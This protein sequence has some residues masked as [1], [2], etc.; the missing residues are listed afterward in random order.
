M[1]AGAGDD[2]ARDRQ[3]GLDARRRRRADP[4][5]G[6]EGRRADVPRRPAV[7]VPRRHGDVRGRRAG[8]RAGHDRPRARAELARLPRARC[9]GRRSAMP[10]RGPPRSPA[11]AVGPQREPRTWRASHGARARPPRRHRR[12]PPPCCCSRTASRRPACCSRSTVPRARRSS[13]FR[14]TRSRSAPTRASSTSSFGGEAPPIPVP[15]D[16]ETLRAIAEQTGGKYYNAPSAEALSAAY[17]D[18]GSLLEGEPGRG[19]GDVRVPGRRR[20]PR[21]AR[22]RA[23]RPLAQPHSVASLS[24]AASARR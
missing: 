11:Q 22:R 9:A 14:S 3:L 21:P 1:R 18:L 15:P 2:R 10:S 24:R 8:G 6:G 23:R 7:E 5:R 4:A 13:A 17:D 19:R 20:A 16:R 12:R